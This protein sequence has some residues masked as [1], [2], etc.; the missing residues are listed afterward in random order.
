M[1]LD[2]KFSTKLTELSDAPPQFREKLASH[3]NR[4]G[5][6]SP[7][8]VYAPDFTT[9][10]QRSPATILA[11]DGDR[12][13]IACDDANGNVAADECGFSDTLLLQLT[14]ILL[15]GRL[16]IDFA[17]AGKLR[18]SSVYFDTVMGELY[19]TATQLI[20]EGISNAQNMTH[21][22]KPSILVPTSD[23]PLHFRN[24]ISGAVPQGQQILDAMQWPAILG[25]FGSELA[26]AAALL[27]TNREIILISEEKALWRGASTKYGTIV[28]HFPL[29]R[30][31]RH[32][33]H[34]Q[35][36]IAILDL[37]MHASH[38]GETLQVLFPS[39]HIDAVSRVVNRASQ[40]VSAIA[41]PTRFQG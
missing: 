6:T 37:E 35:S 36:R 29:L 30:L 28:T 14:M 38:G 34:S 27:A 17:T 3:L 7:F 4:W 33:I 13:L 1:Q 16:K 21:S 25:G 19:R 5:S 18:S 39:N 22:P 2:T 9:L 11:I 8:L 32:T 12:W 23:W 26:P 31:A 20:L 24:S 41:T 10:G 15:Y 40:Q